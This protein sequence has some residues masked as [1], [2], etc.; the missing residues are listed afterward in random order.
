M[1]RVAGLL[2]GPVVPRDAEAAGA[3]ARPAGACEH[4]HAG[5]VLGGAAHRRR[6]P[7]AAAE[8]RHAAIAG[9][10][11]DQCAGGHAGEDA[12]RPA[13][14]PGHRRQARSV[15]SGVFS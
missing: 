14:A 13:A 8:V 7:A 1:S 15:S 5:G 4:Q 2:Q 9:A 3:V 12:D 10:R 6:L 11:P